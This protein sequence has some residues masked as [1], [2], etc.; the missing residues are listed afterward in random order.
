MNK[1]RK[2]VRNPDFQLK[3]VLLNNDIE[4]LS[5][6]GN[7]RIYYKTLS[8][9]TKLFLTKRITT[10]FELNMLA[11]IPNILEIPFKILLNIW[12]NRINPISFSEKSMEKFIHIIQDKL[13][14][15]TEKNIKLI[16]SFASW[17]FEIKL[18]QITSL[19][20][21]IQ[22]IGSGTKNS[23]IQFYE[24]FITS[25][26]EEIHRKA[27][28]SFAKFNSNPLA[29]EINP[30]NRNERRKRQESLLN[31][32]VKSGELVNLVN[33]SDLVLVENKIY[34]L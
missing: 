12:R 32:F 1:Y 26:N 16:N 8:E 15:N 2:I 24:N 6:T 22:F 30:L 13:E 9:R 20:Y 28:T 3:D 25:Q 29:Q 4:L 10:D 27:M 7:I 34:K 17:K 19:L 11:R 21:E 23:Q 18:T 33:E 31:H 5:I 14:M